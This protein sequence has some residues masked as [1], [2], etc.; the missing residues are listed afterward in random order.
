MLTKGLSRWLS[1]LRLYFL[2][3]NLQFV[4][5]L[6]HKTSVELVHLGRSLQRTPWFLVGGC[7]T[8]PLHVFY[9]DRWWLICALVGHAWTRLLFSPKLGILLLETAFAAFYLVSVWRI[10]LL[11][12][13]YFLLTRGFKLCFGRVPWPLIEAFPKRIPPDKILIQIRLADERLSKGH[14]LT[15]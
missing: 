6:A 11:Y 7:H 9:Q 1:P 3:D 4:L 8:V 5:L 14:F 10:I 15:Q 12:G 2:C 13:F